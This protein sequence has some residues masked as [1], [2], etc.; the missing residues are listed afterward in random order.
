MSGHAPSIGMSLDLVR[1]EESGLNVL[2]SQRQLFY[3]GW[4]LRISQSGLAR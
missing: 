4:L 1:I 3:D 2:Q